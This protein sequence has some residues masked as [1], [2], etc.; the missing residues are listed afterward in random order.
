MKALLFLFAATIAL[1]Q[2][3]LSSPATI[4]RDVSTGQDA[5]M[6][7]QAGDGMNLAQMQESGTGLLFTNTVAPTLNVQGILVVSSQSSFGSPRV[8][9]LNGT[10]TTAN[11]GAAATTGAWFTDAAVNDGVVRSDAGTLLLGVGGGV[12]G[13]IHSSISIDQMANVKMQG[14]S[15]APQIQLIGTNVLELTGNV[16][17]TGNF[18]FD[19]LIGGPGNLQIDAFSKVI[20][21][22]SYATCG[23]DTQIQYNA[24]NIC[25]ASANFEWKYTTNTLAITGAQPS[26]QI[27]ATGG[28]S[29]PR[30]SLISG[31]T[32][33]ANFSAETNNTT[34]FWFTDSTNLDAVMRAD[35]GRA[36]IGVGTGSKHSSIMI[37]TTG[38]VH[39]GSTGAFQV[40][41]TGATSVTGQFL[42]NT[43]PVTFPYLTGPGLLNLSA[44][45]NV[46]VQASA[47]PCGLNTQIQYNDATV[48]GADA[49]LTWTKGSSTL[50]VSGGAAVVNLI[51]TSGA[52][53]PAFQ[54][55]RSSV[56]SPDITVGPVTGA[57]HWFTD[58][59]AGDGAIRA[60]NGRLLL[61]AGAGT[62]VS[63][64]RIDSMGGILLQGPGG[65]PQ[66]QLIG[67]NVL[68]LSGNVHHTGNFYFDSLLGGPA[69]LSIDVMGKVVATHGSPPCGGDTQIQYN[70]ANN[71]G[72]DAGLTWSHTSP[73]QLVVNGQIT[74]VGSNG[75]DSFVPRSGSGDQFTIYNP[76]GTD[77]RVW[78]GNDKALF[79]QNG[80][81]HIDPLS[82]NNGALSPGYVFG[83]PG[84]GEGIASTRQSGGANLYGIDFYS[85]AIVRMSITNSGFVGIGR[86]NPLYSLDVNGAVNVTGSGGIGIISGGDI[87]PAAAFGANFGRNSNPIG[88]VYTGSILVFGNVL[89][90]L[91][92]TPDNSQSLGSSTLRWQN[93]YGYDACIGNSSGNCTLQVNSGSSVAV[94]SNLNVLSG[95][96]L[97]G[98]ST[99]FPVI[100]GMSGTG[101]VNYVNTQ[102]PLTFAGALP[103]STIS[104]P[105]CVTT[106]GTQTYSGT[107]TVSGNINVSAGSGNLY[108]RS[109]SGGGGVSCAGVQDG[110][111]G[112]DRTGGF[113]IAC[114]GGNRYAVQLT[115]F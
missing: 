98:I 43:G 109:F 59:A 2:T 71:C 78:D 32:V 91:I 48:C 35:N 60:G 102:P 6:I 93:I 49:N 101:Q 19:S 81:F 75:G 70:N 47:P 1:A 44:T 58:S 20:V 85:Q 36:L 77:L 56:S 86:T 34:P 37:D 96:N 40:P 112:W 53:D 114:G 76:F 50:Q 108:L 106:G 87:Y 64:M 24:A 92:P 104:C 90:S 82:T 63:S 88:T 57:G 95:I 61:G 22:N 3:P 80:N 45:G 29:E 67:T 105:T 12:V 54:G 42:F 99:G 100:L 103:A 89:S 18:F 21:S 107:L 25:G 5:R 79:T 73:G 17:H 30:Y 52:T 16:H 4:L 97:G 41:Y 33:A 10:T 65:A 46:G 23:G 84:S 8:Q 14:P 9:V 13:G 110:W 26:V 11:F 31:A 113:L 72:A 62:L 55:F 68:E 7:I 115:P 69:A 39:M 66:I 83:A 15:G 28:G 27:T 51:G 74:M 111:I 94:N 38:N